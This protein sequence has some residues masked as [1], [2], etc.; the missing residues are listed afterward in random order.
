MQLGIKFEEHEVKDLIKKEAS[1]LTGVPAKELNVYI[2][3]VNGRTFTTVA[4]L[5]PEKNLELNIRRLRK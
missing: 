2:V 1:I 5:D 4:H 3:S